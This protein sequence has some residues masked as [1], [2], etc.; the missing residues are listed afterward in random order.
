MPA[1][2]WPASGPSTCSAA[3]LAGTIRLTSEPDGLAF[4]AWRANAEDARRG[5]L[6]IIHDLSGITADI[7]DLAATFGADGYET[8]A[9]DFAARASAPAFPW[10]EIA[11]D[12][13]AAIATLAPPVFVVGH[14]W[15][16]AVA[17]R[18]A[19][20]RPGIAAVACYDA[21][22]IADALGESPLCPTILHF[23]R[24]DILS[25]AA[26]VDAIAEAHPDLAVHRYEA[27]RGFVAAGPGDQDADAAR[28]ARL[29]T[30][31][32]FTLSGGGRGEV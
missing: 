30:L 1:P 18:A 27:G 11:A 24:L 9:P 7:R 13:Q 16:G 25:P 14:G 2:N 20:R 4:T 15:G 17:W 29:R 22:G 5:G 28:L 31:R 6:V 32:L 10:D 3:D 12:L 8:L 26:M 19:C 23:G 21:A